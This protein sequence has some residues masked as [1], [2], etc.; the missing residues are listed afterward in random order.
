VDSSR[1]R[2]ILEKKPS[3]PQ[4]IE[5]NLHNY[6]LK[7]QQQLLEESCYKLLYKGSKWNCGSCIFKTE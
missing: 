1:H 7:Q 5:E 6:R 2:K 3:N 4:A